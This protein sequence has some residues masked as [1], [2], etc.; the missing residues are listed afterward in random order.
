MIVVARDP[1]WADELVVAWPEPV[2][3]NA[4]IVC[5]EDEVAVVC[6]DW[7]V[8]D[9]LGPGRHTLNMH[10]PSSYVS[11]YFV[12]T[13]PATASFDEQVSV[14]DRTTGK[15][16]QVQYTGAVTVQVGD[17][18]LLCSQ[19]LGVPAQE[20]GTGVRRSAS[21]SIAAA[22]K[23]MI[24]KVLAS[25]PQV[26]VLA[27]PN[28]VTQLVY[29][30]ASGNPMAIAVNG[31]DFLGFEQ[32]ALA[33]DGGQAVQAA[34]SEERAAAEPG[35]ATLRLDTSNDEA[36]FAVGDDVLVYVEDSG[37]WHAGKVHQILDAG[38]EVAI[39]GSSDLTWV[40]ASRVRA[41]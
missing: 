11:V 39:D 4:E 29:M 41:P 32:L 38:Y 2:P 14:F 1:A 33:V 25:S 24:H 18:M 34:L 12:R 37:R 16:S 9:Q 28:A 40:E 26:S 5:G 35:P 21:A 3:W 15:M 8:G 10:N 27:T 7:M 17:P 13:A 19:F 22:L 23:V 36:V 6:I 30:T 31:I 20:L